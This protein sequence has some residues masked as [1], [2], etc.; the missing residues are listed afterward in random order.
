MFLVC[1]MRRYKHGLKLL[2]VMCQQ[3]GGCTTHELA[4]ENDRV[5]RAAAAKTYGGSPADYL[6]VSEVERY[7]SR[8]AAEVMVNYLR[9]ESASPQ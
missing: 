8:E 1:T 9:E 2:P 6:R 3:A 4:R 5:L 7:E